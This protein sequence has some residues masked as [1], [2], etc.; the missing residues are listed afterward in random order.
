MYPAH[1]ANLFPPF[2]RNNNVFVAMSF[3]REFESRWNNVIKPAIASVQFDGTPLEA[4]RVDVR[5]VADSILTEILEGIT[6]ARLVLADL[7]TLHILNDVACRNANVMYEVG[8]AQALRLPEEVLLFRSDNDRLLFDLMNV[9]VNPYDPDK[10]VDAAKKKISDCISDAL[11]EIDQRK[12]AFVRRAADALDGSCFDVLLLSQKDGTFT[13]PGFKHIF[14]EMR[15]VA[16][17]GRLLDLGILRFDGFDINK[18]VEYPEQPIEYG[19]QITPF[20]S[21]VFDLIVERSRRK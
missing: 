18:K 4:H 16:A 3:A 5:V 20:G 10:D 13:Q 14:R 2:P 12:S 17:I 21:A 1:Y 8:I 7:T 11:K 9:R 19:Y 15:H 6:N